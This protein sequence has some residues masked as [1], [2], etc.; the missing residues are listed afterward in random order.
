M[1]DDIKKISNLKSNQMAT[2]TTWTSENPNYLPFSL[3]FN[4]KVETFTAEGNT[5]SANSWTAARAAKEA[6]MAAAN[7]TADT[8]D[9]NTI[10][11]SSVVEEVPAFTNIHQLWIHEYGIQFVSVEV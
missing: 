2:K 10:I 11:T 9:G 4:Q 8:P 1:L 7:Y 3:W 6:A 5:A